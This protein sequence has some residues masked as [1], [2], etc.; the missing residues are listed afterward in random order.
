MRVE[1]EDCVVAHALGRDRAAAVGKDGTGLVVQHVPAP[2]AVG[3]RARAWAGDCRGVKLAARIRLRGQWRQGTRACASA[4]RT[5]ACKKRKR[6]ARQG[7]GGRSHSATGARVRRRQPRPRQDSSSPGC[8]Q[9]QQISPFWTLIFLGSSGSSA[10]A[11]PATCCCCC[12]G[13]LSRG[14]HRR[15]SVPRAG[16]NSGRPRHAL[17][18]LQASVLRAPAQGRRTGT[19]WPTSASARAARRPPRRAGRPS[20]PPG[21]A[22]G[23]D[24]GLLAVLERWTRPR[25]L[26]A[27]PGSA[28]TGDPGRL[29]CGWARLE[30]PR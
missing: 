25:A 4:F 16:S 6:V 30:G 10:M 12:G 22:H 20:S 23:R 29:S 1:P 24:P 5:R 8:L 28:R 18:L 15:V 13:G 9:N 14:V 11:A 7:S 27:A 17:A 21:R 2:A 19:R 26:L 3:A